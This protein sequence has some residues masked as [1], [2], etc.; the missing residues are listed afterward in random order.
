MKYIF[1]LEA[2]YTQINYYVSQYDV[3]LEFSVF[4]D[5][6]FNYVQAAISRWY[7]GSSNDKSTKMLYVGLS[8]CLSNDEL[9]DYI[10]Y[11]DS[12]FWPNINNCIIEDINKDNMVYVTI[13]SGWSIMFEVK[14]APTPLEVIIDRV[15]V[16]VEH[17]LDSGDYIDPTLKEIYNARRESTQLFN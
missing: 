1:S 5:I 10:L 11:L 2:A 9:D 7:Y 14:P 17:R 8:R 12:I 3:P 15:C 4:S 13:K 6:I 16:D